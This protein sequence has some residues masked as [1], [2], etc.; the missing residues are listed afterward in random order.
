M[1]NYLGALACETSQS[2][3]IQNKIWWRL[4]KETIKGV[5]TAVICNKLSY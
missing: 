1:P 5:F 2:L 4:I 3:K